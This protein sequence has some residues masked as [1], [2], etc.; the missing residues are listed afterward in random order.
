MKEIVYRK[1]PCDGMCGRYINVPTH[2]A[3]Q[4]MKPNGTIIRHEAVFCPDCTIWLLE[5]LEFQVAIYLET[6]PI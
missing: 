3:R 4:L 6:H 1:F 5:S 2:I